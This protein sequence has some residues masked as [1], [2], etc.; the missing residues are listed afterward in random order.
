MINAP[1]LL[2]DL[3]RL[4]KR[5]EADLLQRIEEVP[6]LKSSLQAEW[7]AARDADRC[8]E[9]FQTWADQ[10]I[11]QAAVHWLLSCV[12]LRFIEDN[13]LVDR[14]WLGGTPDS[15]R[16]ALVRDRHESYFRTHP[17]HSDR[18]YLLAC[19]REAGTLPGL[20]T[21]FDE[22]HNP[23]FRLGISGAPGVGKNSLAII[24]AWLNAYGLDLRGVP[25]VTGN[26]R[27]AQRTRKLERAIDYLRWHG[28][29]VRRTQ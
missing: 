16:L 24:R 17:R 23:V 8:A 3:T 6:E 5:L 7:Q 15:G 29:E 12:F 4:L 10:V 2:S 13:Q 26:S 18:D 21:F 25:T 20:H 27:A 11:T 9:P 22:A 1:Q 14:P 28:Y 19:F